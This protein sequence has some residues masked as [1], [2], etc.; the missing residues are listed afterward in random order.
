[1]N[2][3]SIPETSS[4][5]KSENQRFLAHCRTVAG[6]TLALGKTMAVVRLPIGSDRNR[7]PT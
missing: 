2:H 1:M 7:R 5:V 3:P 4:N 6:K